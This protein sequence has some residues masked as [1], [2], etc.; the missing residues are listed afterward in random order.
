[1]SKQGPSRILRASVTLRLGK[2]ADPIQNALRVVEE[3]TGNVLKPAGGQNP[4]AQALAALGASEGGKA[5]AANLS[6]KRRVA[7]ARKAARTRWLK[8]KR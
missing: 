6:A 5:R 4:R 2:R 7:I 3:A 1:M 8:P